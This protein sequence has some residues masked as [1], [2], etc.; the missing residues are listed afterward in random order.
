VVL[1]CVEVAQLTTKNGTIEEWTGFIDQGV[2]WKETHDGHRN[3]RVDVQC[4][5]NIISDRP[6]FSAKR[7]SRRTNRGEVVWLRGAL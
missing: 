1:T 5:G 6:F 7:Q 2:L 3:F 4:E